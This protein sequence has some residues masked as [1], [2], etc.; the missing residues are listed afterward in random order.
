MNISKIISL[1][2][3]SDLSANQ[4]ATFSGMLERFNAQEKEQRA[5]LDLIQAVA[6]E[7]PLDIIISTNEL[8]IYTVSGKKVWDL[9]YP[10]RIIFLTPIGTWQKSSTVSPSL[11]VAFIIYL[12]KKH[13]GLNSQ[14][15]QFA[16]K[17]LDIKTVE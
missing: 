14:F 2:E 1:I 16:M 9:K 13:L 15:V 5:D 4:K 11:D 8:K 6:H 12:E 10:Y 17:M 3:E 7:I